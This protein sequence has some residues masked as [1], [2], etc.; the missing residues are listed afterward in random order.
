M[1]G[2]VIRVGLVYAMS[3]VL[4]VLAVIVVMGLLTR[5]AHAQD[6]YQQVARFVYPIPVYVDGYEGELMWLE[7]EAIDEQVRNE[8]NCRKAVERYQ[9]AVTVLAMYTPEG[10][11]VIEWFADNIR[12]HVKNVAEKCSHAY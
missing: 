6:A 10:E 4:G 9:A 3:F 8:H 1:W 7:W 5:Y 11:N 12:D 2:K